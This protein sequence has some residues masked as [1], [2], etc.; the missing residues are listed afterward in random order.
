MSNELFRLEQKR[1]NT[2]GFVLGKL[3]FL[4]TLLKKSTDSKFSITKTCCGKIVLTWESS[5]Q[6]KAKNPAT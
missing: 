5:I 3:I 4:K 1:T 2:K 6:P